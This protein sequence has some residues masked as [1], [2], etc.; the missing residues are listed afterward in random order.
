MTNQTKTL[1][2]SGESCGKATVA[3]TSARPAK[4]AIRVNGLRTEESDRRAM[5]I[6][7][8]PRNYPAKRS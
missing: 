1:C 4:I 3:D 6:A 8:C 7:P 5:V 2:I